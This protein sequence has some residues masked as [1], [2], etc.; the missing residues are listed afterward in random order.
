MSQLKNKLKKSFQTHFKGSNNK[1]SIKITNKKCS[2]VI[3]IDSKSEE[4]TKKSKEISEDSDD[5]FNKWCHDVAK[6]IQQKN[7]AAGR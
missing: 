3:V 6:D 5:D 1:L 7:R 2:D 4:N